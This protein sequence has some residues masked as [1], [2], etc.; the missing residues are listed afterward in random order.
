[1]NPFM[2]HYIELNIAYLK[3]FKR[4]LHVAALKDDG[5]I[6]KDEQKTIDR[7]NKITDKYIKELEKL[8]R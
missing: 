2:K 4:S 3:T 1:M 7:A 5:V 8:M 6:D